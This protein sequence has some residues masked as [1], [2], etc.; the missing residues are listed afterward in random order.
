MKRLGNNMPLPGERQ[1]AS[2]T[3]AGRD[4]SEDTGG[5][6]KNTRHPSQINNATQEGGTLQQTP[7]SSQV[8]AVQIQAPPNTE[9]PNIELGRKSR[10]KWTK[11][12]N[13]YI[14]RTYLLITK[15]ETLKEPYSLQL[16]RKVIEE[17]PQLR[18]KTVQN[19]LDQRRQLCTKS[20][21]SQEIV[22]NIR[23]DVA[24]EL[25]L[26]TVA[27]PE[28]AEEVHE[29]EYQVLTEEERPVYEILQKNILLYRGMNPTLRPVIPRLKDT[30][31][32]KNILSTTNK[33]LSLEMLN[34]DDMSS[35]HDLIY[36]AAITTIECNQQKVHRK[37]G[38]QTNSIKPAWEL[39]LERKIS[40]IRKNIGIITQYTK[41]ETPCIKLRR[42]AEK[43]LD[44]LRNDKNNNVIEILDH[45]KQRLG[46]LAFRLRKYRTSWNRREDNK[47]FS[48]SQRDFYRG[49]GVSQN[50]NQFDD[51]FPTEEDT[52]DFWSEIWEKPV[53]HTKSAGWLKDEKQKTDRTPQMIPQTVTIDDLQEVLSGAPNWRAPGPD[54][55]QNFWYKKFS[56][57]HPKLVD[58]LCDILRNPQTTPEFLTAGVTYLLP[59][60]TPATKDPS[61]YR[62]ITCL[63]TVYKFLTGII[64]K[65]IYKHLTDN[66]LLAEEQKG[67]RKRS[68]GYK[69]QVII[70]TVLTKGVLKQKK[71]LHVAYIDFQKAFDSIPHSWLREC[72]AIYKICPIIVNFL[73]E[74]MPRWKTSLVVSGKN[75]NSPININIRRGIFQGDALSALWF[76]MAL[77]PLSNALNRI[78]NESAINNIKIT[79]LLYMD[80]IKIYSPSPSGLKKLV[81]KTEQFSNDIRMC[82]GLSKCRTNALKGGRWEEA[83]DFRLLQRTGGGII[84]AMHKNE[85]YKYLGYAQARGIDDT[86]VK[87]ELLKT[88]E[89]KLKAVLKTK[90]SA[91]NIVTAVNTYVV[92]SITSSFGVVQW[93]QTDLEDLNRRIRV[94]FTKHRA[95]H[96]KASMERFHL[97]RD[98][99]GRGI[100]DLRKVHDQQVDSL[101]NYFRKTATISPLHQSI[102]NA[103]KKLTP[104]N[105][106]T[107]T[108]ADTRFTTQ[109]LMRDWSKKELHGRY[110]NTIEQPHICKQASFG[111]L[112]CGNLFPETEGFICSI[113]DQM[114]PT[115]TYRKHIIKDNTVQ[116][117]NCRMC[118]E[119]NETIEHLINGCTTLAAREYTSRHNNVAKIVHRELSTQFGLLN[120]QCAYYKYEPQTVMENDSCLIYWDRDIL[121]HHPV[122]NNRPDITLYNKN[123]KKVFIID[124]AVP[125]AFNIHRKGI[126]KIQKYMLLS[127][128]I[129]QIWEVRDV[130]IIPIVI[131]SLGEIPNKLLDNL[132]TIKVKKN[133]YLEMQKAVLLGTCNIIRKVLNLQ[134]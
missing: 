99:G 54:R 49:L 38:L 1:G 57:S 10:T 94:K 122:Q 119:A 80:D 25:G 77:N 126:E 56:S 12:M 68:Q 83:E 98:M 116:S 72:L 14:Y 51:E 73:T 60:T 53:I 131:G 40:D 114:V 86:A 87:K 44:H 30:K 71:E 13:H 26:V 4:N 113:Q 106:A 21:L 37:Q 134:E 79:H 67:C 104:L 70:D 28:H 92:P 36:A 24:Q 118:G 29:A 63:P 46:V 108:S 17:F 23:K 97:P 39:R 31:N 110:I 123:T 84:S 59:K 128:E 35:F 65:K 121:T 41:R 55:I 81:R 64:S 74:M 34:C 20:R 9:E 58:I 112:T 18:N 7:Q 93:T 115:K 124:I 3:G 127:Q 6:D 43:I 109:T 101:R 96:P 90:L 15:M 19:I 5:G 107:I 62:P 125:L 16:H 52:R 61:K 50:N 91:I 78:G 100:C 111:W 117:T 27:R 132:E 103:D 88:F 76:C 47:K 89:D 32:S 82:F 11:E 120:E 42:K 85:H 8:V 102:V 45:L 75:K 130:Q 2:A 133:T 22:E 129:K 95:H 66:N 105:L 48:N 69:E 33:L